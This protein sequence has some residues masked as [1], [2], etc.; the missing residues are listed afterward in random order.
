VVWVVD[1]AGHAAGRDP[2]KP[3][4]VVAVTLRSASARERPLPLTHQGGRVYE[5][6]FL[7]PENAALR[8][9]VASGEFLLA[10]GIRF[11]DR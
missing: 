4:S 5:Y 9:K 8:V 7:A 1:P 11:A 6:S 10:D 2:H 3:G